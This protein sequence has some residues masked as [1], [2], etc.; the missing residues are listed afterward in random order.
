MSGI[1]IRNFVD[2][3]IVRKIP[4]T[5]SGTRDIAVLFTDEKRLNNTT[6]LTEEIL[7]ASLEEAKEFESDLPHTYRYC[8]VYFSNGGKKLAIYTNIAADS[9]LS[10]TRTLAMKMQD[11]LKDIPNEYICVAYAPESNWSNSTC[12][13]MLELA[14]R[15]S[16]DDGIDQ[17]MIF[18]RTNQTVILTNTYVIDPSSADPVTKT[19]TS[20]VTKNFVV[21]YSI[22]IDNTDAIDDGLGVEMTMIAYLSKINVYTLDSIYD[23]MFTIEKNI[24][25][26]DQLLDDDYKDIIKNNFNVDI[27]LAN[28][29]RNCGGNC[30]NS[31]DLVNEYVLIVMQQTITTVVVETLATKLKNQS[32]I[33][34]LYSVINSELEKYKNSGYLTTDK[35][36]SYDDLYYT[37]NG[38]EYLIIEK[39]TALQNGYFVKILPYSGLSDEEKLERKAPPIYVIIAEQY[40]IRKVQIEGEAF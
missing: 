34:T 37:W 31:E 6:P 30:T 14:D 38:V 16:K 1:D 20:N 32:G 29:V 9:G 23:Y 10:D 28:E 22:D 35:V 26:Q 3:N 11:K 15:L 2:V 40:G 18:A 36:W 19:I 33:N 12:G 5:I 8:E 24:K 39:G 21:K 4:S 7:I 13:I 25:A 17:R 27:T